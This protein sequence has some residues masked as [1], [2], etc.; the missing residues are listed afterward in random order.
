MF[1]LLHALR[2]ED[3]VRILSQLCYIMGVVIYIVTPAAVTIP[4]NEGS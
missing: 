1:V 2:V 3:A 4:F